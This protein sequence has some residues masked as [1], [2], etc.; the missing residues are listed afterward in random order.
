MDRLT[1]VHGI[2]T[3]Q[4]V[5]INNLHI[6][7]SSGFNAVFTLIILCIFLFPKVTTKIMDSYNKDNQ[8]YTNNSQYNY[9]LESE[10]LSF[11]DKQKIENDKELLRIDD[12]GKYKEIYMGMHYVS[13]EDIEIITDKIYIGENASK[14]YFH[15]INNSDKGMV[16]NI[17]YNTIVRHNG[18]KQTNILLPNEEYYIE[19]DILKPYDKKEYKELI[20][21]LEYTLS[22]TIFREYK[23]HTSYFHYP[24]N[25]VDKNCLF[26]INLESFLSE[27]VFNEYDQFYNKE[28]QEFLNRFQ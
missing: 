20:V 7:E 26:K 14:L 19:M 5:S 9:D 28:E 18:E 3:K 15:I 12:L 21:I 2:F 6:K 11:M 17:D 23:D 13:D 8:Y 10:E 4:F 27:V 1:I 24:L 22:E 16:I 25:V